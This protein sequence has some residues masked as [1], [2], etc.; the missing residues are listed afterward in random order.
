MSLSLVLD[1][2]TP[3]LV[4]PGFWRFYTTRQL[5]DQGNPSDDDSAK[6]IFRDDFTKTLMLM[7]LQLQG[8]WLNST[9]ALTSI[10]RLDDMQ[11]YEGNLT[12]N[13]I[14]EAPIG[15]NANP[16]I[17]HEPAGPTSFFPAMVSP[18]PGSPPSLTSVEV[19]Y[20]L[21]P[22]LIQA[23]SQF[24]DSVYEVPTTMPPAVSPPTPVTIGD[25]TDGKWLF[26]SKDRLEAN[27]ALFFRWHHPDPR[28]GFP[29]TYVF[30]IGQYCLRI[31][32][33]LVEVFRDDSAHGDRSSWKHVQKC[34]LWSVRDLNRGVGSLMA[35]PTAA[36]LAAHDRSLLWLPFRRHQVLLRANTGQSALLTVRPVARRLADNSDWDITREDT[37][38]C[39]VMTPSPGHFQ[40]QKVAYSTNTVKVQSPT[41][42]L[43]YT[44]A[45]DPTVTITEDSDHSTTLTATRSQ[46]PA[47]T[48]PTN[49]ANS[50]PPASSGAT[51][52]TRTYGVELS[53]HSTDGRHTPYFYGY[54]IEGARTF[55]ARATTPFTV[56]ASSSATYYLE[57]ADISLGLK[58]GEGRMTARLIDRSTY[59]LAPYYYRSAM[60]VTLLSGTDVVF[61]GWTE[62][63]EVTPMKAGA[64]PRH[65]TLSALDRWKQLTRTILRDQRDWSNFGHI[66]VVKYIFEQGG[67]DTTD[68]VSPS[69]TPGVAGTYNTP[70]S[71]GGQTIE[72]ETGNVKAS[73]KPG[74]TETAA[75]FIRK[76]AEIFSGWYVGFYSTGV[77]F[78]LPRTWF[79]SPTVVFSDTTAG[80]APHFRNAMFR[81][82]EPEANAILVVGGN[83]INGDQQT[84]ALWVDWASILNPNVT[85]YLGRRQ[86]ETVFLPG[87]YTCQQLNWAARRIFQQTRRRRYT[88]EFEA[89]YQVGLEVGHVCTLGS[90][91]SYRITS[92]NVRFEHGAWAPARYS[93]EFLESGFGL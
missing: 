74:Q 83:P 67:V 68:F 15:N 37:L 85:N 52:Q 30:M 4:D 60:P 78:Y 82:V 26:H 10:I 55:G 56:N 87:T 22:G 23:P 41:T 28:A 12:D 29:I 13:K 27:Q 25:T 33:V 35:M 91:G 6:D 89:D 92:V 48:L 38:A 46:P 17:F 77:P 86:L 47:Y 90:Y 49:D 3:Q 84:S 9:N 42:T 88:V 66:E 71:L 69:Y 14:F 80:A 73:W 65:L 39:W 72:Q 62:P 19:P 7:P 63:N 21:A 31:K 57:S 40:V 1:A 51:D 81:T 53:F 34:P 20:D 58:P 54:S 79:T 36:D 64:L 43:D 24:R 16:F 59:T 76:I 2:A 5:A 50:C 32:D 44:P 8:D 45:V 18:F 11:V 61:N 70:L 93:A 75:D